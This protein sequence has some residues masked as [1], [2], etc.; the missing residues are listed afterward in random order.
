MTGPARGTNALR[1]L[2]LWVSTL[3]KLER[4]THLSGMGKRALITASSVGLRI[5]YV[6]LLSMVRV[7]G[8]Y[9]FV[10]TCNMD[11]E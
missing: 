6:R 5:L 10:D 11:L 2:N 8:T 1:E 7:Y 9:N 3:G 4:G